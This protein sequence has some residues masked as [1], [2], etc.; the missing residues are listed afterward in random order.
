MRRAGTIALVLLALISSIYLLTVET[1]PSVRVRWRDAVTP[2]RQAALEDAYLLIDGGSPMPDAPR[3]LAYVLLDTSRR[4][5]E[6]LVTNAEVLD[7]HDIDREAFEVVSTAARSSR[8]VWLAHRVPGLRHAAVRAA[9]ILS[10]ALIAFVGLARP[11]VASPPVA[12]LRRWIGTDDDIFDRLDGARQAGIGRGVSPRDGAA[13]A[14]FKLGAAVIVVIAAGVPIIEAWKVFAVAGAL[15]A[16]GFGRGRPRGRSLAVAAVVVLAVVGLKALLPRADIAEAHN[17]FLVLDDG[18]ALERG[19]PPAVFRSWRQQFE[20]LYPPREAPPVPNSWRD[21]RA[22]PTALFAQS[23]DAIWRRPKHTRQIDAFDFRTLA[24]FRG[25]FVNDPRYNFWEGDL[26][27]R[28]LPFYVMYELTPASV[29]SRLVW[30]GQVFWEQE[31][32]RFDELVHQTTAGRV[33][34]PEDAGRRVYAAAFPQSDQQFG[35]RLERSQTLRL[36]AWASMLLSVAGVVVVTMLMV[37]PAWGRHLRAFSLFAVGYVLALAFSFDGYLGGGYA[38]QAGGGD[39][40]S[41]D[42]L[43][44]TMAMLAGQGQLLEAL[45]GGEPVY[46][47]TPGTRYLRMLEKLVFG[48][49]NYLLLLVIASMPAILF[50]LIRRFV[51][52]PTAWMLTAVFLVMPVGNLS[53]PHYV[54]NAASGYGDAVGVALF[55]F[56]LT[57]LLRTQAAWGGAGGATAPAAWAAG[58]ALAA[59]VF[60]RPNFAFAVVWLGAAGLWMFWRRGE[61]AP[62]VALAVGLGL[63]LWMPFHN[64]YY[65]G[66]FYLISQ[67]GATISVPL[68]VSDYLQ[69]L[70]EIAQGRLSSPAVQTVIAQV[71]GWLM[72]P[73]FA[74]RPWMQPLAWGAHAIKLAG[75]VAACGVVLRWAAARFSTPADLPVIGVAALLAH[76]PMLVVFNTDYRYAMLGWDLSLLVLIVWC[77]RLRHAAGAPAAEPR[78]LLAYA[79]TAPE[80]PA[81]R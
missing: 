33:I 15:L 67:S 22:I 39:G 21:A 36:A 50:C 29:G 78:Q 6:A 38:P 19:L 10:L 57:V 72:A 34:A 27:R 35:M 18:E 48:D 37:R 54:S 65:G 70:V 74:Y 56:A 7:T 68:G 77:A 81:R 55:L 64:W 31:N 28:W 9:V 23:A 41:H 2:E 69:A 20:A 40:M 8:R 73:G 13:V 60:L 24:E 16:I 30:T 52:T 63:A 26:S 79:P 45:K 58:A 4:N 66:A 3:S 11:L 12:G 1:A 59:A 32:G 80:R 75:L 61:T 47:L 76:A 46:W 71:Q 51:R 62:A 5:I 42:W 17:A 43:G 53:F 49:S 44:R 14:L 25:G